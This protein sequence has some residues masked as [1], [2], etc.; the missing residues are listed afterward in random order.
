ML[1][2]H[3]FLQYNLPAAHNPLTSSFNGNGTDTCGGVSIEV[4]DV[5]SNSTVEILFPTPNSAF[6]WI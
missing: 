2:Q 6:L 3:T 5:G 4:D 1:W